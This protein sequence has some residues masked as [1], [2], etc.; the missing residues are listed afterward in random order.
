MIII[1]PASCALLVLLILRL[2]QYW[3][4]NLRGKSPKP[5][6]STYSTPPSAAYTVPWLSHT[7]YFVSGGFTLASAMLLNCGVNVPV[8]FNLIGA[9]IVLVTGS[10][11]VRQTLNNKHHIT[12][13]RV[14]ARFIKHALGLHPKAVALIEAD[15]SGS[16]L[17]PL[18]GSNVPDH[19]RILRMQQESTFNF[20]SQIGVRDFMPRYM[21]CYEECVENSGVGDKW[22]DV[23]DFFI[24]LRDLA[25]EASV[26]TLC[27]K[28]F[29]KQSPEFSDAIWE[30]DANI[31]FLY[32]GFP[33]WLRPRAA[34]AR[35]TCLD[36]ITKWRTTA[37]HKSQGRKVPDEALWDDIWGSKIMRLRNNM[38]DKFSEFDLASR[39][40]ADLGV[41]W[42]ANDNLAPVTYWLLMAMLRDDKIR[43][44]CMAEMDKAR[45]PDEGDNPIPRFD[46][47]ILV[48]QPLLNSVFSEV[49]RHEVTI[50]MARSVEEDYNVG[51]Y[52]LPKDSRVLVSSHVEHMD[53]SRWETRPSA[54]KHP[55]EEFWAERFLKYDE[56]TGEPLFSLTGL[57]GTFIPFG[58]GRNMCPGRHFSAH[59]I[60]SIVAVLI[61][62]FDFELKGQN[63]WCNVTRDYRSFGYSTSRPGKE[64][65]LR[66]KRKNAGTI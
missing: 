27:G 59:V 65:P 53:K 28:D 57:D 23:S 19:R 55:V 50:F 41:I 52:T 20:I 26:N 12:T 1:F 34:K 46:S 44:Q 56:Q 64:T 31:H 38:Y 51:G 58:F 14:R 8:L 3:R 43:K 21:S 47:G 25:L 4:R 32:M 61:N 15:T 49:L 36:A 7:L 10:E 16:H 62:T 39:S 17:E 9:Q 22:S 30:F 66:L 54:E 18:P 5:K 63:D 42:A 24:F 33:S 45:L 29:L 11:N 37:V 13:H 35:F 60:L 6:E 40:G 2:S 48:K